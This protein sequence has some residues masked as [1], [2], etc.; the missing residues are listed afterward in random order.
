MKVYGL[1]E[2][3]VMSL[4]L[5]A[6]CTFGN[7]YPVARHGNCAR[8]AAQKK[9]KKR[10][11]TS[12]IAVSDFV[13]LVTRHRIIHF[14]PTSTKAR[15]QCIEQFTNPLEFTTKALYQTPLLLPRLLPCYY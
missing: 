3:E 8:L 9:K 4:T 1:T 12:A 14:A 6:R 7:R 2:A 13:C 11:P 10:A 15:V 5:Q